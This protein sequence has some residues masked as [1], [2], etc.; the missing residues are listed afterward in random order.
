MT[1][2]C[3]SNELDAPERTKEKM[4]YS[5]HKVVCRIPEYQQ[6]VEKGSKVNISIFKDK[7]THQGMGL[8]STS[9]QLISNILPDKMNLV[10]GSD[11][12]TKAGKERM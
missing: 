1:K 2:T 8:D 9:L 11:F 3:E 12:I 6:T 10:Q 4:P 7:V 5:V